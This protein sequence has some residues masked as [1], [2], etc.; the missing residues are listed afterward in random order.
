MNKRN[1]G[2]SNLQ[3]SAIG[4]G[5]MG[6]SFGYGPP[7][8][9]Q[10]GISL[11][12][13]AVERGVT[14]FDTAEVYGP[15]T[16]EELV[17][18]ALAP[19]RHQVKIATKFG[20]KIENGRQA[21]LDSRPEHIK[22]VAEASLKRLKTDVIDLFYQHRVDDQVPIEDVAGA[23]KDLIQEGKVKHFGLSEAGVRTIRRAHCVQPVA[24]LQS[25]YSL[26]W[27][28]PEKEIIPAL[29]ELGIGFV[30]F[31][32]LGKGFLTGTIS[33]DT[34]FDKND[35][36]NVVP[37]FSPD[38]RDANQAV[39]DL[40]GRFAGQ[41][42]ATPAQVALAWILAQKPWM[43]PIPGTTKLH[44]LEENLGAAAVELTPDD[45]CQLDEATSKITVQGARY[46]EHLQKMVGR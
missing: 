8:E 24:A 43:V 6:L 36:R 19:F 30:P 39:V 23:V 3:V 32:P 42:N 27:R 28:E 1:L 13:A 18:E 33:K 5:C 34:Q 12:R 2:K 35:F 46:P 20:F 10:Q 21:G 14:F 29:D 9:K 38:N 25:E 26:W 16:N 22:E 40:I 15:Y 41:K 11:I 7:V 37:R 31:S 17:G 4:L 44:R 45:L